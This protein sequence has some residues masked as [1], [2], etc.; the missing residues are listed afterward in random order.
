[1]NPHVPGARRALWLIAAT[2]LL[3]AACASNHLREDGL[4]M[5]DSGNYS[6]GFAKLR[7]ASAEAPGDTRLRAEL[8]TREDQ[9]MRR[10][11][12]AA[13]NE[14]INGHLDDARKLYQQALQVDPSF[15]RA[16]AGAA[17]VD[18]A[19]RHLARYHQAEEQ[20][21]KG[22][23]EGALAALRT[24]LDENPQQIEARTLQ[25]KLQ[26]DQARESITAPAFRTPARKPVTLEFRDAN[27]KLV[28]EAIAKAAGINILLDRDVKG[29]VKTTIFVKDA[30]VEDAIDLLLMQNQL[31]KKVVSDN[32]LFIYPNLPTKVKDY[33]DLK[34]RNFQLTNA[35]AKQ[36][37][38][39]LKTLL[40]T[41]D[42]F[43]DEK[44]NSVI[45]RDT[46]DAI[47][48][49]EKLINTQDL[50]EP[51]VL[52]EVEVLE[53]NRSRLEQLG[54]NWPTQLALSLTGA[55]AQQTTTYSNGT[56]IVTAT[57]AT[58][59]TLDNI[60]H[61]NSGLVQVGTLSGSIDFS[62]QIG[63]T[64]T[65]SSPRIRVRNKEKAKILIGDR[66]PVITNSVTPTNGGNSVVTG[67]VTYLDVGLKL[68]VEPDVHLDD[69]IAIKMS[70][71]VSNIAKTVT[72]QGGTIAYQIGT[73]TASTVL[74]L[75][76]G[77]TQILAGLISDDDRKSV[78]GI[79]GLSDL[80]ILGRL[81]GSTNTKKAKSEIVLTITPHL[82]RGV[83]RPSATDVEFWT[84]TENTLRTRPAGALSVGKI[85]VGSAVTAAA[86]A[87]VATA[88][89]APGA[90]TMTPRGP[91]Q[92]VTQTPA[93]VP[94]DAAAQAAAA[95]NAQ[96]SL[97]WRGPNTTKVGQDVVVSLIA[98]TGQPVADLP[99]V[100]H[101]DPAIFSVVKVT[102]GDFMKQGGAQ[103][104]F[105][106]D[107]DTAGGKITTDSSQPGG[108]G[109]GGGG[110]VLSVTLHA[111]APSEKSEVSVLSAS[112]VGANGGPLGLAPGIPLQLR[113]VP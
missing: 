89:T 65:L 49:A 109:S 90:A 41:R 19:E 1:M 30:T 64:N 60:R 47:R 102:E 46:P 86:G 75:K 37:Q 108:R 78:A 92:P 45:M 69:D 51:E 58:N 111:M 53:V 104:Q 26:E 7:A 62:K 79:D 100:L 10:L 80:P 52:L 71:E 24:I 97:S 63:D 67:S 34:I 25:R 18:L 103:S 15:P 96:L 77:E 4:A 74:R 101:F 56:P 33:Q 82:I 12:T 106:N 91:V 68:D 3:L 28:F 23:R 35:D 21:A 59:L 48:L 87:N 32:T 83:Q 55:Q 44:T 29:D 16:L 99:A 112:P 6:E 2:S 27:L 17:S 11:M 105:T 107:V 113:V 54:I 84:G 95:T 40:K 110:T 42:L 20:L 31:E 13:D 81:F 5:I 72:G 73:R 39:M 61:L 36:I 93:A 88:G 98:R 57:P 9:I 38:T 66:V 94:A 70:L 76:D 85:A 22:D 14:R 50:A 8:R 43:I